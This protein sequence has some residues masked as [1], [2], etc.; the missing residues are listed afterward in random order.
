[1]SGFVSDM[2]RSGNGLLLR[3]SIIAAIGGLLLGYD[4]G[5]IFDAL[6]FIKKDLHAGAPGS[7]AS[8]SA[9]TPCPPMRQ[10]PTAR[11]AGTPPP[12]SWS[13][14]APATSKGSGGPTARLPARP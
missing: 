10:R 6:L 8:R 7:T 9:P 2:R 3:I 14:P 5:V 13:E 12:W 11:S 4:T 1:M